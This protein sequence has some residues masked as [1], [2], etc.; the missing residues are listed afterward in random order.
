MHL[1]LV[2]PTVA[3]IVMPLLAALLAGGTLG[4]P[5]ALPREAAAAPGGQDPTA[6]S[7]ATEPVL[8]LTARQQGADW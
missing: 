3:R 1:L 8:L 7:P 6:G 5:A 2:R 4:G